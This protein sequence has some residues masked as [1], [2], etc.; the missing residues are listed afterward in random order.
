MPEEKKKTSQ[1]LTREQAGR[2]GGLATSRKHGPEFY[3]MIGQRGGKTV[4]RNRDHMSQI[5]QRGGSARNKRN[6]KT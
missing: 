2:R 5:G 4:S 3:A 1:K 6:Q